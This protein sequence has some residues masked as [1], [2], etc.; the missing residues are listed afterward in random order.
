MEVECV[1][2]PTKGLTYPC[3]YLIFAMALQKWV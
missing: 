2:D 1:A 3:P